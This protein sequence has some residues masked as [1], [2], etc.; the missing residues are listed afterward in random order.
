MIKVNSVLISEFVLFHVVLD[1]EVYDVFI[2]M[3][4][5]GLFKTI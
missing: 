2:V 1:L 5:D 3:F 4:R